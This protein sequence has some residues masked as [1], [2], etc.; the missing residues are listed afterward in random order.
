MGALW[1]GRARAQRSSV[2]ARHGLCGKQQGDA[3][4]DSHSPMHMGVMIFPVLV[5][6]TNQGGSD[7]VGIAATAV[8]AEHN[9]LP[10]VKFVT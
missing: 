8:K 7:V 9:R 10:I 5:V 6:C 3:L 4:C 2:P 1:S